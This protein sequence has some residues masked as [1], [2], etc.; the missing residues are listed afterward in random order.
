MKKFNWQ[1]WKI[2]LR[3]K[4]KKFNWP[5][6]PDKKTQGSWPLL[7]K[8]TCFREKQNQKRNI[9]VDLERSNFIIYEF[10]MLIRLSLRYRIAYV[11]LD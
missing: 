8:L 2:E 1:S 6:E 11:W 5:S 3:K 10:A 9:K 4:M 7:Q